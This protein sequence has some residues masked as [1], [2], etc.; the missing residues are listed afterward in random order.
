[1][2][3]NNEQ[4]RYGLVSITLHWLIAVLTIALFVLGVWMVELDYYDSWYQQ[5]PWWHKGLGIVV[6]CLLVFRWFWQCFDAAPDELRSISTWQLKSAKIVHVLMN[7]SIIIIS[8]TGYLIV[9]AKGKAL[10]VFDWFAIPA[11][12]TGVDNLEDM[13]GEV[14]VGSAYL[15]IALVGLHMFAALSHHFFYRDKTLTR[16]LGFNKERR[17]RSRL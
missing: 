2:R 1:M 15:L 11:M 10:L 7:A 12:V 14:H 4:T 16:M 9:T 6:I 13:A 3:L 5:A 17:Q 8:V